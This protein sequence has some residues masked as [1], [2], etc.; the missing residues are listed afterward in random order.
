M[1]KE[2]FEDQREVLG[3]ISHKHNNESHMLSFSLSS[4]LDESLKI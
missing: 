1:E 3:D 4:V 2:E